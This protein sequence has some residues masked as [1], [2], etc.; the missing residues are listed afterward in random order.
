VA[1]LGVMEGQQVSELWQEIENQLKNEE[2]ERK[3]LLA[4]GLPE[5]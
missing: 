3:A 2:A 1:Q 5:E 4:A